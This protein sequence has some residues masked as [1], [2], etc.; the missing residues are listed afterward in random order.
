MNE[1]FYGLGELGHSCGQI[2]G[3]WGTNKSTG[4]QNGTH[5]VDVFT[6]S[7]NGYDGHE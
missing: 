3:R 5:K 4:K 7:N 1:L 2:S 6:V